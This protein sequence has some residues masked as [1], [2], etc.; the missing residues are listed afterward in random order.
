MNPINKILQTISEFFSKMS[1]RFKRPLWTK[2]FTRNQKAVGGGLAATAAVAIA[3]PLLMTS[4]GLRTDAYLDPVGIPT[5][6]YGETLGVELGQSHTVEEC[7]R[8][9]ADRAEGFLTAMR[10]CTTVPLPAK[11]EAAFLSFTYNLGEGV[12][13]KNMAR[14]RINKGKV[15][16]ACEA[17]SLYNKA[18]GRVLPG[19]V[20]RRAEERKLCLEGLNE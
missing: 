4:E 12:Y 10:N 15:K 17:L 16:E 18:G 1:Q 3:L 13:C 6:C 7:E 14:K 11:T 19:L 2:S 20:T 5:I 8:M 9:L